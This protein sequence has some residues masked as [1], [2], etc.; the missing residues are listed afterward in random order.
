MVDGNNIT[1]SK[2]FFNINN[3]LSKTENIILSFPKSGRTWLRSVLST[4]F[5]LVYGVDETKHLCH[6]NP[7]KNLSRQQSG[8]PLV[9]FTHDYYSLERSY[10]KTWDQIQESIEEFIFLEFYKNKKTIVLLRD[11]IDC[12]VSFYHMHYN[13]SE[14]PF[15][16]SIENWFIDSNFNV[17][18]T[19]KWFKCLFKELDKIKNLFIIKYEDLKQD[20]THWYNLIKFITGSCDIEKCDQSLINNSFEKSQ[21][22]ELEQF[23]NNGKIISNKNKLFVRK[24]GD[25]YQIELEKPLQDYIMSNKD[26][27]TIREKIYNAKT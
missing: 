24:G 10:N 6:T 12:M 27:Q 7:E 4:Y 21:K 8:C 5:H 16:D 2:R 3:E 15:I 22:K 18:F 14:N 23:A 20:N 1:N 11:P 26:L 9:S 25:N 17:D 19:C 13:Y